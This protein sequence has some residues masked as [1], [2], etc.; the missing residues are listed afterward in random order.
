MDRSEG[1]TINRRRFLQALGAVGVA[2]A[3]GPAAPTGAS[4]APSAGASGTAAA[5]KPVSLEWW[6]RNYTSGTQNAETLTSD[7]AVRAFREKNPH[8]T[9]SIQGGPFGPE[10][11]QKF[12]IAILQQKA[13][14]DVFHTTGGDVL[15]YAAAGQLSEPPLTAAERADFN[16]SALTATTYKGKVV[17]YPLWIVP[18][19][20]YINL[21]LFKERGVTPPADGNWTYDQ[22]LDAARKL[23][24]KRADGKQIY[25]FAHANDEFAFML[26]DGGRLYDTDVKRW[27]FNSA[28]AISGLEKWV[29]L[30]KEKVM[31]P[32]Y[33]TLNP[34]DSQARFI[35]GEIAILQRPSAMI[36]VLNADAKWKYG[37][38]WD[39]A[40]FPKGAT[41]QTAWGGVGFIAVREQADADKKA[42][43][44]AFAKYLTGPDIGPDL[45]K[46]TPPIEYWLAPAARTSAAGIYGEYHAAKA[47]VA[48]MGSFTYVL[49][50]VSTWA[51][52][53]QKHLRPA[54]D[55]A[56]EGKKTA[57]QALDEVAP[58]AQRLLDEANK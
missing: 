55:A 52:I 1:T 40:N 23:T 48:K 45:K 5:A 17:A 8:F 36:N 47:K 2:V 20:E 58:N 18:W 28:E 32:D 43:A 25:G 15:K 3:C 30:A 10:T 44:H 13:G 7:G 24:F 26:I 22:F 11:D 34:N 53:D 27:T 49:P 19:F 39:I 14:P 16:T 37:T 21:D 50:N 29:N 46:M 12:D 42:A 54:R 38:N 56:L 31:P 33:L 6:R 57:K 41:Q 35:A 4:P 51:E 9:I